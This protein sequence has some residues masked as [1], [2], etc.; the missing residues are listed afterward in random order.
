MPISKSKRPGKQKPASKK[1][2]MT[3][4][5]LLSY[6]PDEVIAEYV[7]HVQAD[8]HVKKLPALLFFKLLLFG[9]LKSN[10]LSTHLL[11]HY[12]N[13]EQFS[14]L[15]GK[16]GHR[17]RH[18]SIADRLKALPPELFEK[19][20]G[21]VA[22]VL[23]DKFF[24]AGRGCKALA[25]K[26]FDSTMVAASA[27][28]LKEGMVV[29]K[30]PKEGPGKK[31]VKFSI[32]LCN[33]FPAE[34]LVS[35]RQA[36]LSEDVALGELVLK[37]SKA[38]RQVLVFDRGI[39]KRDTLDELTGNEQLFVTR[40]N[41]GGCY[42]EVEKRELKQKQTNTLCLQEDLLVRLKNRKGQWTAHAYR[43]IKAVSKES[44]EEFWFL[45]NMDKA[46]A[47]QITGIYQQR[48][49][50]EVFFKF[51]KQHLSLEHLLS[52][53]RKAIETMLYVRLIAAALILVYKKENKL[54]S[55]KIAKEKF[56]SELEMEMIR[57]LITESGGN[58][59]M[60]KQLIGYQKL[61]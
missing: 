41:T 23:F 7:A 45:S 28:L 61:W 39:S 1:Q 43:L 8:K 33:G 16:G 47:G 22:T 11:E 60:L 52:Y 42:Q 38:D 34:A 21:Y 56:T 27:A 49:Q 48:W 54:S 58:A 17:T 59:K 18:S 53:E 50:I 40:I 44:G 25:I 37:S 13:S 3:V 24:K 4:N 32:S 31:Q 10:R 2:K 6:L 15:A 12:Y 46:S 35:G 5:K 20:F 36:Y 29:G 30:K 55:Y 26:S 19:L 57:Y 9:V 14:H 51:L